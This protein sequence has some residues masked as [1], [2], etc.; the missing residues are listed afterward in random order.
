MPDPV[1]FWEY[2][3]QLPEL[4]DVAGVIS[5]AIAIP[6]D[7]KTINEVRITTFKKA[8]IIAPPFLE[9]EKKSIQNKDA[10]NN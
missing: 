4:L 6:L 10:D 5:S 7:V 1:E 9:D 2:S 8:F 3:H